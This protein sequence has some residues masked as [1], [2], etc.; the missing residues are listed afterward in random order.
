MGFDA[1]D[2]SVF[3]DKALA[4]EA[5]RA[6]EKQINET[7]EHDAAHEKGDTRTVERSM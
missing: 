5:V 3:E 2:E 7:H 4:D 6:V 1:N